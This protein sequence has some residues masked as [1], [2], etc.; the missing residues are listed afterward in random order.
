MIVGLAALTVT[1]SLVAL[2]SLTDAVVGVAAVGGVPLVGAGHRPVVGSVKPVGVVYV[3]LPLTA[4]VS[5]STRVLPWWSVKVMVPLGLK[6]PAST[7]VSFSVTGVVPSV[8]VVG[9]GQC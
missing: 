7:A 9:L 5:V 4:T 1:C 2:L 3:P 6:P 8:T